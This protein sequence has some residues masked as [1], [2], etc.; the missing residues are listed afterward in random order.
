MPKG[1]ELVGGGREEAVLKGGCVPK[2]R[3]YA[4]R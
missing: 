3:G 2:S 4:E 1:W